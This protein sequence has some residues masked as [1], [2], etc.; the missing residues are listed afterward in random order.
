MHFSALLTIFIFRHG[1]N[2]YGWY[3]Q[4]FCVNISEKSNQPVWPLLSDYVFFH[5]VRANW[6]PKMMMPLLNKYTRRTARPKKMKTRMKHNSVCEW[7]KK[8]CIQTEITNIYRTEIQWISYNFFIK[9]QEPK[10]FINNQFLVAF[11]R[12]LS[13]GTRHLMM[14]M[15][16]VRCIF[17]FIKPFKFYERHKKRRIFSSVNVKIIAT[18]LYCKFIWKKKNLRR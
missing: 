17:H 3:V 5:G 18:T 14:Y 6:L 15:Y 9:K 2:G 11:F 16:I 7:N 13:S 10:Q 8:S 4:I 1:F 12:W